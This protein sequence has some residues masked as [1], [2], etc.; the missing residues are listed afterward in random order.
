MKRE[1]YMNQL[2]YSVIKSLDQLSVI[3]Q[4]VKLL[5]FKQTLPQDQLTGEPIRD[6]KTGFVYKPMKVVHIPVRIFFTFNFP[7]NRKQMILL[8]YYKDQT[9][10]SVLTC[11]TLTNSRRY[12]YKKI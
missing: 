7:T 11:L 6:D 9:A 1:F 8:I 4:E 3:N 2:R 10:Q 12:M 5:E